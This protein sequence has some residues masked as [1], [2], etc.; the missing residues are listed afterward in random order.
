MQYKNKTTKTTKTTKTLIT[1]TSSS[2]HL[3]VTLQTSRFFH[4][5]SFVI[6]FFFWS[7]II[8]INSFWWDGSV[9]KD[10]IGV[11]DFVEKEEEKCDLYKGHWVPELRGPMY[12]N[13]S[14]ATIPESK[15]CFKNGRRDS[16][17]L[18][19]RWKPDKCELP[20]FDPNTFLE[21]VRG[22]KMAFIGDSVARN[23]VESLLC[24]L[25]QVILQEIT[26][27]FFF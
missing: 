21:I 15:N 18:N 10:N 5:F 3:Q 26:R 1:I 16:D 13:S 25:S 6:T 24:L 8:Y 20:L 12:T 11:S 27:P 4:I 19:W 2:N 7:W 17:F 23:H 14:C 22:K 9:L